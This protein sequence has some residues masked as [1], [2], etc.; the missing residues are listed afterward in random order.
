MILVVGKYDHHQKGSEVRENGI[1]YA[2]FGLLWRGIRPIL[3]GQEKADLFDQTFVQV[4]DHTGNTGEGNPLSETIS[5]FNLDQNEEVI[6]KSNWIHAVNFAHL[7]LQQYIKS[8]RAKLAA[9]DEVIQFI[10]KSD[11]NIVVLE[12]YVPAKKKLSES[13]AK[14]RVY[15]SMRGAQNI[16]TVITGEDEITPKIPLPKEQLEN[17]PEGCHFVHKGLFLAAFDTKENAVKAARSLL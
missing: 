12:Q 8:I 15:L 7:V 10:K 3:V 1:P 5:T 9:A 16:R 4:I 6:V 11:G 14:F 17:K 13:T 2:T